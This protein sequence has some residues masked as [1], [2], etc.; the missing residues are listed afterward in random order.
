MPTRA[1]QRE[2]KLGPPVG[3]RTT[4]AVPHDGLRGGGRRVDAD[5]VRH[6]TNLR[7][8]QILQSRHG[9]SWPPRRRA[10]S[11]PASRPRGGPGLVEIVVSVGRLS[12]AVAATACF[13]VAAATTNVAKHA[14]AP[15]GARRWL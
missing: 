1:R 6:P 9:V 12:A 15:H 8:P 14:R 11:L 3:D 2:R 5:D 10:G 4:L 13:V 7:L